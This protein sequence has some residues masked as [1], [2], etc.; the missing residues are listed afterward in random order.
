V[1]LKTS[2]QIGLLLLIVALIGLA[3]VL[4]GEEGGEGATEGRPAAVDTVASGPQ[5]PGAPIAVL[6]V[7]DTQDFPRVSQG[8]W[9]PDGRVI[10]GRVST[11][12]HLWDAATG[13]IIEPSGTRFA[14]WGGRDAQALAYSGD[15]RYLAA[16]LRGRPGGAYLVRWD[17]A[18]GQLVGRLQLP[19]EVQPQAIAMAP[20]GGRV[21]WLS[22]QAVGVW[23]P[24]DNSNPQ[25]AVSGVSHLAWPRGPGGGDRIAL[26]ADGRVSLLRV[27]D[28]QIAETWDV[29]TELHLLGLSD[30]GGSQIYAFDGKLE[31]WPVRRGEASLRLSGLD[32]EVTSA[33]LLA[34]T[35]QVVLGNRRGELGL[36]RADGQRL[37]PRQVHDAAIDELRC[38]A[39]GRVLSIA[40]DAARV[41]EVGG[42][43]PPEAARP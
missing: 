35:G 42:L 12:V 34:T 39:N 18:S 24:A 36:W 31:V 40:S 27:A 6:E 23:N 22:Q 33:C 41:W 3:L 16:A 29:P 28:L 10:A 37:G 7:P 30:D 26:V 13:R 4:D 20:D 14:T 11:G 21:A 1:A 38:A 32:E 5:G 17:T 19:D 25:V 43:F 2:W 9:S 15:G 8:I